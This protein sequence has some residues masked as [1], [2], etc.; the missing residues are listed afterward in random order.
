MAKGLL[1]GLELLRQF[2]QARGPLTI[3]EAVEGSSLNRAT[4][5]RM[6]EDLVAAGWLTVHEDQSPRRYSPSWEIPILGFRALKGRHP[7]D[8]LLPHLIALSRRTQ[9]VCVLGFYDAGTVVITDQ[10]S[11][12]DDRIMPTVRGDRYPCA[13]TATGKVLLAF[14]P[15]DELER[16][17][18]SGAP[19]FTEA[20]KTLPDDIMTEM[21]SI[22]ERGWAVASGEYL[23]GFG[24]LATPVF[25]ANGSVVAGFGVRAFGEASEG[26]INEALN[27]AVMQSAMES[28]CMSTEKRCASAARCMEERRRP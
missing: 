4:A 16:V 23:S 26:F 7:H 21:L 15:N 17:V 6:V 14:Q 25:N 3:P 8:S 2:S 22:R 1:G 5:Y 12:L 13:S 20:S 27:A 19:Q 28:R 18:A 10:V 11:V 9:R 24:A